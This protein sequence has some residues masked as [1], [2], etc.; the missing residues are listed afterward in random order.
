MIAFKSLRDE[1]LISPLLPANALGQRNHA[2]DGVGPT[3]SFGQPK[4]RLVDVAVQVPGRDAGY[5]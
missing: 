5:T 3:V 2:F 1:V 4:C